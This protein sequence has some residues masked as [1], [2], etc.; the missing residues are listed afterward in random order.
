MKRILKNPAN[1]LTM[2]IMVA[3]MAFIFSCSK[4]D[5]SGE[6]IGN[7]TSGG[8]DESSPSQV[9][10]EDGSKFEASGVLKFRPCDGCEYIIVGNITNGLAKLELPSTINEQ[11]LLDVTELYGEEG[12]TVS[13]TNAKMAE[14]MEVVH[15]SDT[16][17]RLFIGHMD[18]TNKVYQIIAFLYSS[19]ATKIT[20]EMQYDDPDVKTNKNI[21][22]KVGWNK[23]YSVKYH[24][25]GIRVEEASTDNILTKEVGWIV[26]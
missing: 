26:M 23:V 20:C 17:E 13:Q 24:S 18:K 1:L 6:P 4:D 19:K 21:D 11:Y 22:V 3:A 14:L 9:L 25:N 2:S 8:F 15:L 7:N 16:D 10:N 12:C 5:D